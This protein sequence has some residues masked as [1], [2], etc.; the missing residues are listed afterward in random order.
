MQKHKFLSIS[1]SE[2][3]YFKIK[4]WFLYSMNKFI[5]IENNNFIVNGEKQS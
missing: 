5:L 2:P 1:T 3:V 4:D